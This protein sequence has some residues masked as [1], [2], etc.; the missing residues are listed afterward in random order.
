MAT[1]AILFNSLT[2]FS[3]SPSLTPGNGRLASFSAV[4]SF[5]ASPAMTVTRVRSINAI[6]ATSFNASPA[7][8]SGSGSSIQFA[9]VSSFSGSANLTGASDTRGVSICAILKEVLNLWGIEC[10]KNAPEFTVER[11]LNDINGAIQTVWNRA[12]ERTYWT[13]ETLTLTFA[14]A[15]TS[16][17]LTDTIQN[18]VGPCRRSDDKTPLIPTGTLAELEGFSLLFLDGEVPTEPVAY[19]IDREAQTGNDPAKCTLHIYPGPSEETNFLLDVV[20]E[21]PRYSVSDLDTCPIVPI[22]HRYAE[23]LLLPIVRYK[24]STYWLFANPETAESINREYAQAM[25]SLG[26]ADPLPGNSGDNKPDREGGK[27]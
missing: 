6:A 24:A 12:K 27:Q 14:M 5:A 23:T 21:A 19:H 4:T 7:L 9:A 2:A 18:V 13:N 17:A 3:A 26:L 11:A 25:L 8:T 15:A 22:P 1:Q 20:K 10:R 16:Q